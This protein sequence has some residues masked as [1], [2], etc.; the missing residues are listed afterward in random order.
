MVVAA[1]PKTVVMVLCIPGIGC[2]SAPCVSGKRLKS[3][4]PA[5]AVP[6]TSCRGRKPLTHLWRGSEPL[7]LS[8]GSGAHSYER[9]RGAFAF[10]RC[11]S[12]RQFLLRPLRLPSGSGA[13]NH[14]SKPA[15]SPRLGGRRARRR[16]TRGARICT[17]TDHICLRSTGKPAVTTFLS[18][19]ARAVVAPR[20]G[21]HGRGDFGRRSTAPQGAIGYK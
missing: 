8:T 2:C 6:K 7:R 13:Q 21:R 15:R 1:A 16:A 11:H 20:Q 3:L 5:H 18:P 19:A 14:E 9:Q 4:A 12:M 10:R 17:T